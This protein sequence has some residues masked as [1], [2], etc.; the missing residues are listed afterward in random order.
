ML[1]Y[2]VKNP[3]IAELVLDRFLQTNQQTSIDLLDNYSSF[4]KY[5]Y[6][7]KNNI[8]KDVDYKDTFEVNKG[9]VTLYTK[10]S[11]NEFHTHEDQVFIE[12]NSSHLLIQVLETGTSEENLTLYDNSTKINVPM[13]AGDIIVFHRSV[14]HGLETVLDKLRVLVL[15]IN[16]KE[17]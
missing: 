12:S 4:D 5:F 1:Y 7:I 10:G 13:A 16:F 3:Q 9:W 8:S 14:V 2:K 6:N 15:G 17:A 11:T